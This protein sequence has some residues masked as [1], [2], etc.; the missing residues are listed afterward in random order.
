VA[1][2]EPITVCLFAP[3]AVAAVPG[4]IHG[5]SVR[6]GV[7]RALVELLTP[8]SPF[9][10]KAGEALFFGVLAVFIANLYGHPLSGTDL[11]WI[12]LL[13]FTAAIWSVGIAGV[14]SVIL[15]S[16]VL[17]SFG[18]PLEAVLPVFMLLE[19]LCEGTRN[20]LSFLISS[21][22]IA[23]AADDLYINTGQVSEVWHPPTLNLAFTRKQIMLVFLLMALALLTVFCAGVGYGLHTTAF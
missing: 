20:L 4:F 13:S 12:C 21:A 1:L 17:A 7:S 19:V 11:A 22:L 5:M 23:L 6:L 3:V 14:K 8:I 9:F 2:R 15:G 10:L 16:F 18:L